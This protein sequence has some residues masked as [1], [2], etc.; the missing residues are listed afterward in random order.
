MHAGTNIAQVL[1]MHV[2]TD[3]R[4]AGCPGKGRCARIFGEIFASADRRALDGTPYAKMLHD[5]GD[6][7]L[8]DL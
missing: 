2:I 8:V 6:R 5:D 3:I 7:R 4:F 1:Y